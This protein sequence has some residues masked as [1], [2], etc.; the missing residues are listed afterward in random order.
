MT[1]DESTML[2]EFRFEWGAFWFCIGFFVAV[3]FLSVFI[4]IFVPKGDMNG[5]GRVDA[6]DAIILTERTRDTIDEVA[7]RY[8]P[9]TGE[10][11][12]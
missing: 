9:P 8:P 2:K 6:M 3:L 10:V 4:V 7:S 1:K 12:R 5:D 11:T